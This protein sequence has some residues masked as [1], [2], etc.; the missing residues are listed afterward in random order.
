MS[1]LNDTNITLKNIFN[2]PVFDESGI[3]VIRVL[4]S[5]VII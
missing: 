1:T 2:K 5:D 4:E 3:E